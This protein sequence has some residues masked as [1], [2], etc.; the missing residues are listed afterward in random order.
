[1]NTQTHF[2]PSFVAR[3]ADRCLLAQ[4]RS[5]FACPRGRAGQVAGYLMAA[6]NVSLNRFAL[7]MLDAQAGEQ[8]LEIG[9]GNGRLVSALARQAEFVAGIDLSDVMVRQAVKHNAG[10]IAAG[11]VELCCGSVNNL[12]Y[13]YARFDR[14]LAVSSYQFWPNQEHNLDEVRRVLRPGGRLV[15]A[16]RTQ[17][18]QFALGLSA[19]EIEEAAGL[20]RWVGFED[21]TIMTRGVAVCVT[22]RR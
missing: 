15:L 20:V 8:V 18:A 6:T 14:A 7:E 5:Q 3:H 19:E 10:L 11:R 21:V 16:L 13:E 22:G 1:M 12:P 9:C 2:P 4:M 17:A